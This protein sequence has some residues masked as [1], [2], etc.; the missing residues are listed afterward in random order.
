VTR[1]SASGR[2]P[3]DQEARRQGQAR[4]G[5]EAPRAGGRGRG[6]GADRPV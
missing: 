6:Q 5:R 2:S 4:P 1:R 3:R